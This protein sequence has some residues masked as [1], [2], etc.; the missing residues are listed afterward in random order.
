MLCCFLSADIPPLFSIP[1][2]P[3]LD[4]LYSTEKL[5]NTREQAGILL[6]PYTLAQS[7]RA[8]LRR[9]LTDATSDTVN[10][11]RTVHT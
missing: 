1:T 2:P 4:C 6:S 8:R 5:R 11:A 3:S 10:Y 7:R 9:A